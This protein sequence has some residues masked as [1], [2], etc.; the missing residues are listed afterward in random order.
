LI[1]A[2]K[3]QMQQVMLNLISNAADAMHKIE[4]RPR[5]LRV[6]TDPSGSSGVAISVEDNGTGIDPKDSNRI[7]EAFFTT[8]RDGMGMGLA[9]CRSIIEAH[10]GT[11][12]VSSGSSHG[13][14]FEIVLPAAPSASVTSRS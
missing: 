6:K 12:S 14:I 5:L 8:K 4:D 7:F 10:G 3:G 11:L 2:H 1:S 9:I 13:S